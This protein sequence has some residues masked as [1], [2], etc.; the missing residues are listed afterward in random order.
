MKNKIR[1]YLLA[2][3]YWIQGDDWD[4]AVKFGRFLVEG[5]RG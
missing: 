4:S 1:I 3:K 5:F 2:I